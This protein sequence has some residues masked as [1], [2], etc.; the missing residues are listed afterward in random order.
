MIGRTTSKPTSVREL[1]VH[2]WAWSHHTV[3]LFAAMS[4]RTQLPRS[5]SGSGCCTGHRASFI[6]ANEDI[7][8]RTHAA[9]NCNKLRKDH[10]KY[11]LASP[12]LASSVLWMA[13]CFG[14]SHFLLKMKKWLNTAK[15]GC[16]I[17]AL[18]NKPLVFVESL[19]DPMLV[20]EWSWVWNCRLLY[21]LC[22]T[23][24]RTRSHTHTR[25]YEHRQIMQLM[26]LFF[27]YTTTDYLLVS[28]FPLWNS[29]QNKVRYFYL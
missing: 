10:L 26:L 14:S 20:D 27:I 6:S 2:V 7:A 12:S 16:G 28:I 19:S 8:T 21:W 15:Q 1:F 23:H 9:F 24:A 17:L 5:H 29:K 18:F 4:S 11:L 13:V 25:I 22:W 3:W